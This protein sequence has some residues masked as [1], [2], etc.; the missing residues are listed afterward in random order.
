VSGGRARAP[1][2]LA[3]ARLAPSAA[4]LALLAGCGGRRPP[5]PALG[6]ARAAAPARRAPGP[7]AA[8][9]L[10]PA[11]LAYAG[12]GADGR[13]RYVGGAFTAE[14]RALLLR[15][16][17]VDDPARLYLPDSAPG[18]ILRYD[19]R[20]APPSGGGRELT[21]RVGYPSGRRADESWDGFA[22]RVLRTPPP[23]FGPAARATTARL[24]ALDEDARVG[25]AALLADARRAGLRVRVTETR[26]TAERQAYLLAR[27]G[28]RTLT[29]TS[30][31]MTGRAADVVVGD[32]DLSRAA[33]R[34][35]WVAFR[36]LAQ[37]WG[38]GDR[39]RLIGTPE[40][41]WDWPHLEL[42]DDPHGFRSVPDAL[43][44]A[45]RLAVRAAPAV[46]AAA[47]AAHATAA[48]AAPGTAGATPGP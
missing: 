22:A 45:R 25:F 14:E 38:G 43:A 24:D 18:A 15:A 10:D 4:A 29:L 9:P 28:A 27:G 36:R 31:H 5:A 32:G 1:A 40:R 20:V 47:P 2:R 33:T 8:V 37:A 35:Q 34:R 13:P 46:P 30:S 21:V 17:G 23:A 26:R 16:Y 3:A 6:L 42:A 44:A 12:R 41:T 11:A 39:F 7:A 48:G 19:L